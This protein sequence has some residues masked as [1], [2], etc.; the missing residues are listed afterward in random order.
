[1]KAVVCRAYGLQ[2]LAIEEVEKPAAGEG[3]VLLRVR[4][5]AL[6]ALDWHFLRGTPAS[7]RIFLGLRRPRTTRPGRDL[8][9][10][11]ES[12]GANVTRFAPGDRV[13]GACRGAFAEFACA[14]EPALSL[15][16]ANVTFEQGAAAPIAGLTALQ[17]LRDAGRL[18]P[19]QRVLVHGAGGGV[20]SFAVLIAR[21]LGAGEVTAV[22]RPANLE[23]VRALGADH[24]LDSTREDFT[25][26]G[27]R[28][29][30]I[31]DCH[32][33]RPLSRCR[34]ALAPEGRYVLAGGPVT[35][36]T[37]LLAGAL[38][39]LVRSRLGRQAFVSFI[40]RLRPADLALLGEWMATGRLAPVI[41]RREGL[42][43]VAAALGDL[44]AG[45]ARGK[46]VIAV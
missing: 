27:Q 35:S 32:F 25:A 40:A 19:G 4:A 30:L 41:D 20:G 21:E 43:A 36:L 15:L 7:A 13:F 44:A 22:T 11:V 9:G 23:T 8:A 2:G 26:G 3:E 14:K 39:R 45:R 5:A 17:G 1:V 18:R 28:Y 42:G 12:V 16:P 10:V 38:A 34:R 29:D 46:L 6:N 33:D 37:R 24:V 31:L